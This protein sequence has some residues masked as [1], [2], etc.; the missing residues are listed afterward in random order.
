VFFSLYQPS[1]AFELN[2]SYPATFANTSFIR[3]VLGINNANYSNTARFRYAIPTWTSMPYLQV[4]SLKTTASFNGHIFKVE[5]ITPELSSN[6]VYTYGSDYAS[7]S[8]QGILNGQSVGVYNQYGTGKVFT[9]SFP[10]YHMEQ[11]A[12]QALIDRVFGVV[13]DEPSPNDDPLA[14][15]YSGFKVLPNHPNPFHTATIIPIESKDIH[16][17]MTVSVYNLKGQLVSTIFSGIPNAKASYIWD[18]RDTNGKA[19][20]SGVYLLK[21]HQAGKTNTA[22]MLR[23]K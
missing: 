19:V 2:A 17:P 22:K 6:M 13:F 20:S 14:P 16:S 1:M 5:V 12:S 9:I 23:L 10:L 21:V 7:S 3:Q 11:E 18:G 4:D 15:A 8:S